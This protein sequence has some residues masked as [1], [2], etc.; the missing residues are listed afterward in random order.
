VVRGGPWA[1]SISGGDGTGIRDSRVVGTVIARNRMTQMGHGVSITGGHTGA[2]T[3]GVYETSVLNN[4][5]ERGSTAIAV[6]GGFSASGN[7]VEN[8][9]VVNNTFYDNL[10]G[11]VADRDV[12]GSG[13]VVTGL[14]VRNSVFWSSTGAANDFSGSL[15][16][17]VAFSLTRQSGFDGV[18]GNV[19][20]DPRFVSASAG[21]YRLLSGSAATDRGTAVGAPTTDA[22]CTT[23]SG[24]PDIGAFEFGA[25]VN[26]CVPDVFPPSP[27]N[28]PRALAAG[29][30]RKS[31]SVDPRGQSVRSASARGKEG[32]EP[33]R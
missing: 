19:S 22:W 25:S 30:E 14:Q 23:R 24:A 6:V 4:I 32:Q 12:N 9:S 28:R 1:V 16:P 5:F 7:R 18:D 8:V 31:A 21:D 3:S 20:G 13:N 15:T 17:P 2:T 10:S 11:V 29:A 33:A 26:Q 27:T